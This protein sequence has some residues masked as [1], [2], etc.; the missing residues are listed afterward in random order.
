M[1]FARHNSRRS[2]QPSDLLPH[3]GEERIEQIVERLFT[4]AAILIFPLAAFSLSRGSY[5]SS[6]DSSTLYAIQSLFYLG[7]AGTRLLRGRVSFQTRWQI[8]WICLFGIA[9]T[10]LITYG[11]VSVASL[12]LVCICVLVTF[13]GSRLQGYVALGSTTVIMIGAGVAHIN[14]WTRTL[15]DPGSFVVSVT[16]WLH[17]TAA[18]TIACVV[19]V[20]FVGRLKDVWTKDIRRLSASETRYLTLF[21]TA[22]DGIVILKDGACVECNARILEILGYPREQLLG[23]RPEEFSPPYQPDGT[24]STEKARLSIAAALA[25]DAQFFEWAHQ[26]RDGRI[27]ATEVS[28]NRLSVEN[29]ELLLAI[30]RDV[31]DRKR[32]EEE[33]R[34]LGTALEQAAEDII[35]TDLDGVIRY[36]NPAFEKITGYSR[37]EAIGRNSRFLKSGMHDAEFYLR[38]WET[39]LSGRAW[40]GRLINR[41]KGGSLVHLDAIITPLKD[42]TGEIVGFVSLKRDVT[43]QVQLESQLQVSQKMELV[44]QLAGGIAHD[45]NNILAVILANAELSKWSLS[46]EPQVLQYQEQICDATSR[47]KELVR[48][49]LTLARH[50]EQERTPFAV[51]TVVEEVV[52]LIRRVAPSTIEVRADLDQDAGT[53]MGDP[54][55]IHQVLMN[56]CT[57]ALHAMRT[58]GGTLSV[59]LSKAVVEESLPPLQPGKYVCLEVRDTGHGMDAKTMARIFDPYFTTKEPGEG[60]GLGLAVVRGIVSSHGGDI[61]VESRVGRGSVF[62]VYLPTVELEAEDKRGHEEVLPRG[63]ER[64][65]LIDDEPALAA[66]GKDLLQQ[67]G[68]AVTASTRSSDGLK[69]F[70]SNPNAFDLILS[71]QTMPEITG[72]N[73]AREILSIRPEIPVILCTGYSDQIER[74][75]VQQLGIFE[76]LYKPLSAEQLGNAVRQALD[77]RG[78]TNRTGAIAENSDVEGTDHRR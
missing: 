63:R 11:L 49:I 56:L 52:S 28:L 10:G 29:D 47:A 36:V 78:K 33:I 38:M 58:A 53:V 67:L 50:E 60:T 14:G 6:P 62:R 5:L 39:I 48:Q 73:L 66:A 20:I 30:V 25:G 17:A 15:A 45:F 42:P 9:A 8:F 71:D 31:S 69:I 37:S 40:E 34:R 55:R 44:G 70:L 74:E 43:R 46:G 7:I 18:V 22:P 12:A 16:A 23:K 51:H 68:Y 57:N 77:S 75:A 72:I 54:G 41:T 27:V 24:T 2:K 13:A 32:A 26:T 35:I 59:Q 64:I 1:A 65:L 76:V 4:I 21:E 19:I 61:R 3:V